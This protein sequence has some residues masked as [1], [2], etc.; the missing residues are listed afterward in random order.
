MHVVKAE[1]PSIESRRAPR[2]ME[3]CRGIGELLHIFKT[4]TAL[5]N[6]GNQACS[7]TPKRRLEAHG[8]GD[9]PLRHTF[10]AEHLNQLILLLYLI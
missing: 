5:G 7:P 4:L 8:S 9:I 10:Q 2:R 3:A 6:L 1:H